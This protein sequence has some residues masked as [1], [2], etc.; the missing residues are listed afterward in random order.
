MKKVCEP[1]YM[2]IILPYCCRN[3]CFIYTGSSV[4]SKV[5]FVGK[6]QTKKGMSMYVKKF[7]ILVLTAGVV[8]VLLFQMFYIIIEQQIVSKWCKNGFC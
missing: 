4:I 3:W 7:W 2:L 1:K 5:C 6:E 8:S